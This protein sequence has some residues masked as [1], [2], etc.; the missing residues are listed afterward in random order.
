[1]FVLKNDFADKRRIAAYPR[2]YLC[3]SVSVQGR[4]LRSPRPLRSP[5]P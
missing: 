5:D 2:S 3:E 1:M 4:E